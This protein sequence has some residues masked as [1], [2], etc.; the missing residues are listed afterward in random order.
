MI[1][2]SLSTLH[3]DIFQSLHFL[4]IPK[5]AGTSLRTWL[6]DL[7]REEDWL[8]CHFLKELEQLT[9][10]EIN[11]YHFFSGHLGNSWYNCL[12]KPPH[13]F[14]WLR[15]P[16]QREISQ[17]FYLR[18]MKNTLLDM[19]LNPYEPN[20]INVAS[21][22]PLTEFCHSSIH[23]GYYDNLQVRFLTGNFPIRNECPIYCDETMLEIAKEKLLELFFFGL[24]ESMNASMIL[25]NY[26]LGCPPK[27][28]GLFLNKSERN[29]DF[30]H[31]ELKIIQEANFYDQQ[32]Y[33]YAQLI[34][35]E[36]FNKFL[37]EANLSPS[38][39]TENLNI[40][41]PTINNFLKNNF[42]TRQK[43]L[44]TLTD[45][46]FDF[47]ESLFLDNWYPRFYYE[48][49][50]K[51]LR[52]AGPENTSC[53][54]LPLDKNVDF[55]I[56]FKVFYVMSIDILNSLSLYV[57][58]RK[59][60]LNSKI[61]LDDREEFIYYEFNGFIDSS[62]TESASSYTELKFLTSST[63]PMEIQNVND[64]EVRHVSFAMDGLT[65]RISV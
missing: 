16:I 58:D 15:Q 60:V 25:F 8:P 53:I 51:W 65:I 7:Y 23:L 12:Q 34:F 9:P 18:K 39:S 17:Y 14:T 37:T 32:L 47:S 36:R 45:I 33:N 43:L 48:P 24:C 29:S 2:I 64:I 40:E 49:V 55:E 19:P 22:L 42:H 61:I 41:N 31:E 63:M 46:S 38:L 3:T 44:P 21:E 56:S 4:H 13:T 28:L 52:W 20:Y 5:T 10:D 30:S 59:V 62:F 54:Y 6:M 57:N 1:N 27:S 26:L 35:K 50:K 11:K